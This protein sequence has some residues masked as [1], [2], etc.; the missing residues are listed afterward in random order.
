[1]NLTQ[2][3][4]NKALKILSVR[5][6]SSREIKNKL[7][8]YFPESADLIQTILQNF[9]EKS[10]LS[11]HRFALSYIKSKSNKGLHFIKQNLKNYG[12]SEK[13]ISEALAEVDCQEIEVAKRVT[14]KKIIYLT[15]LEKPKQ[16]E[17]LM[18]F[19]QS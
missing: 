11:D 18:R 15:R 10:Y 2:E 9:Q 1:M 17:K 14:E 16:K 4:T 8:R 6:Y 12:V 19:L 3:I 5:E 13:I 7:L